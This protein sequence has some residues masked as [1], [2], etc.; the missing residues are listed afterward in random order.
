MKHFLGLYLASSTVGEVVANILLESANLQI[1]NKLM[2]DLANMLGVRKGVQAILKNEQPLVL[3]L[4]LCKH[5]TNKT[6][7]LDSVDLL[8]GSLENYSC[9]LD[10]LE[11]MNG[12]SCKG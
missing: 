10:A 9:I 6:T 5:F 8:G 4:P 1:V 2:T 11:E 12:C 3:T 7:V